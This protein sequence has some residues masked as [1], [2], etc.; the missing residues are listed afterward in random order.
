MKGPVIDVGI[1]S[2]D[3][4]AV[5][6]KGTFRSSADDREVYG[7]MEFS[8]DDVN[9]EVK[10]SPLDKENSSFVIKNVIIGKDFHWERP[11]DQEFNGIFKLIPDEKK[12]TAV[13]CIH[14]EDYLMSVISSEMNAGA[15]IESLKAHAVISRSW[16]MSQLKS[17]SKPELTSVPLCNENEIIK[18]SDR[19][20]HDNYDVCA[21]DHC[22]RYQGITKVYTPGA[23]EAVRSTTGV[24]LTFD[25]E[26]CDARYSKCCGGMS[27]NYENVWENNS[28]PYLRAV[29]DGTTG[30]LPVL[31]SES[32]FIKWCRSS[33]E[34]FCNTSDKEFLARVLNNYDTETQDFFRW[35]VSYTQTQLTNI[36]LKRTGIDF[37][38]ITDLIPDERGASGRIIKLKIVGEKKT[39]TIGKELFIRQALS[40][41]HLYSSAFFVEKNE[42]GSEV[43]FVLHGAGWGHGV[44]LCQIGAAFMAE[45]GYEY[46]KI[47]KHYYKDADIEEIY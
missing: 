17:K 23:V 18:W 34:V 21:D 25:G 5:E 12:I 33:P 7:I 41:S 27:E 35:K 13:N 14:V 6:F 9:E 44:G 22:Q 8:T 28:H 29:Y 47:L 40:E 15:P 43:E 32:G 16:L 31:N 39:M 36:I 38:K 42:T 2:A 37:G 19:E 26:I 46:R 30:N 20:A 45:K 11:E 1:Y 4:I 3:K 24:V 10:F